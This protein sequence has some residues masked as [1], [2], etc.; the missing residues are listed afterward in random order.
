MVTD[1]ARVQSMGQ[2]IEKAKAIKE[3]KRLEIKEC[4]IR[5]ENRRRNSRPLLSKTQ[6]EKWFAKCQHWAAK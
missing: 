2:E 6:A 5:Y 1:V 3:K 4:S